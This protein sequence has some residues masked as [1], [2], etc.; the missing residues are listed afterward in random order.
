MNAA[1]VISLPAGGRPARTPETFTAEDVTAVLAIACDHMSSHRL[2]CPD[3]RSSATD[4]CRAHDEDDRLAWLA[5]RLSDGLAAAGDHV[6][7]ELLM[8]GRKQAGVAAVSGSE[9]DR[10]E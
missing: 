4:V 9:G 5:Q 3:C 1:V 8:L 7:A 2:D 6:I 10:R